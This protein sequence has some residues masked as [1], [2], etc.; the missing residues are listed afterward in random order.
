MFG[1]DNTSITDI[2]NNINTLYNDFEKKKIFFSNMDANIQLHQACEVLLIYVSKCIV[3]VFVPIHV[4]LGCLYFLFFHILDPQG[5]A[6]QTH[7]FHIYN[8]RESSATLE[9]KL[10]RDSLKVH[11]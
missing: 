9:K 10:S 5:A 1:Q 6:V 4:H 11:R 7:H 3:P 8:K 2:T